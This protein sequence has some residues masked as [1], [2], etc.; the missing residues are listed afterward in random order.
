VLMACSGA[1]TTAA[2]P[3]TPTLPLPSTQPSSTPTS[4]FD[5]P[6]LGMWWPNPWEQPLEQ[7]ARYDW[8]IL[9]PRTEEFVDPLRQLHSDILLLTST[10][11]CELAFNPDP[12]APPEEN[13]EILAI[14]PQWFLTQVGSTLSEDVDASQT[15][16]PVEAL[17]ASDGENTYDLFVPGDAILID[18][19]S[20]LVLDV[21]TENNLLT[22]QRGYVRPAS[23]H[24]AGTRL[25][26]HI[27]FW[28]DSW[29]LNLSTL[30]P[31]AEVDPAHGEEIWAE[32]NA[33]A[34]ASLMA[35]PRWDGLLIDRSD[36]NESW[37]I[38][39][40]TA[41]TID[42][43][44]SNTLLTD[45]AAFDAAWNAGLTNYEALVRQYLGDARIIFVNWGYPN[46]NL[47][48]GNNFEGFPDDLG[49]AN[50]T[51]WQTAVFGA[52]EPGSYFEWLA[53]SRQPN[54]TMIETY[55][56]NSSPDP[57]SGEYDNPCVDPGFIPN[58]RKMRFGLAT[59][60]LGDGFFSYE[61][62]TD[63]HGSLCLLWFDEY[64]NA[65]AGRGY[66]GQPLGAAYRAVDELAAPNLVAGGDFETQADLDLWQIWAEDGYAAAVSRDAG[67][68]A[69]GSSSAKIEVTQAGGVEWQLSFE[70]APLAVAEGEEYTLTFWA[71]ADHSR[72]LSAWV[73][74][75]DDPWDTYLG[76]GNVQL[77][78]SWQ[79]Y[80]ISLASVGS[81][82]QAGLLF[83]FGKD[84]GT[85]WLDDV[86]LQQGSSSVWRRDFSGGVVLLN[87]TTTDQVV[88]LGGNY[89]KIAGTQDAAVND[90][91][92]VSSVTLPPLDGLILLAPSRIYLS[93]A[94]K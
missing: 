49:T 59:T 30:S 31:T 19:E 21:D 82:P 53:N 87:A 79:Q 34:A 17:T 86:R 93:F 64:D 55:E 11:A 90:G 48:N 84:T 67:T 50:G 73:Q 37:L 33:R 89:R 4:S 81:D 80:E 44:Q 56:D 1:P 57:G 68:A 40:S 60:L 45:Y 83:G 2:A 22:V 14:P 47:L 18:G 38:G 43:D 75:R 62:N 66:L 92:Q 32:Y 25:A 28:P 10:N 70:F 85:V 8:V 69:S 7:I 5:F 74:Q 23:A 35:D 51:P 76:Y 26:A 13:A 9:D 39:N 16:L 65:G 36:G 88:Q 12:E 3:A 63:G 41:R 54:L 15:T 77:T 78:T 27:S 46:Y 61:I 24:P 6:R 94:N 91:S 71:K 52:W 29:L 72:P 42:P 58:Y 20:A